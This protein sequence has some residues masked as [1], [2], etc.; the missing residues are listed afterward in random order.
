M[1]NSSTKVRKLA[2]W[3]IFHYVYA[4][5]HHPTYR[6]RFGETLK[7]EMP[8]IPLLPEFDCYVQVGR[9]LAGRHVHYEH[10][11]PYES[12]T[13]NWKANLPVSWRVE[14]M[15]LSKDKTELQANESL[16]L[17]GIPPEVFR[18][19]LANRSALE[20]VIDQYQVDPKTGE[21]PNRS[22]DPE[23]IIR[24]VQRVITVSLETVAL[25]D[26]LPPWPESMPVATTSQSNG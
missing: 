15:R 19:R 13:F 26:S 14:K 12:L 7:K 23:Y 24:L 11:S 16:T 5:L 3:D 4:V 20:W 17:T 21:D 6:E 8:R 9:E 10:A 22:D 18:Y 2:K 25:I 1:Q